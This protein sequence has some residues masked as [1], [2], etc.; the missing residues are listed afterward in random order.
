[1]LRYVLSRFVIFFG[2]WVVLAIHGGGKVSAQTPYDHEAPSGG[3]NEVRTGGPTPSPPGAAAYFVDVKN[4]DTLQTT[5]IIHFGLKGMGIAPAEVVRANS[6]HHHLLIDTELPPLDK[7]IPND[8]QHLHFGAGQTEA[9]V[10]LTPGHH[11][12]QLLLGDKD[13]IPHSPPVM[14]DR[15]NVNVVDS[16]QPTVAAGRTRSPKGARVYFEYPTDGACIPEK[17]V[18]RFGL[19][20]MG[21]APAGFNKRNTGHHHLLIDTELPD[22]NRPIPNDQNHLHFGTGTTE[23]EVTLQPG[24]HELQ[25]LLADSRHIPHDPPLYSKPISVFVGTCAATC[26][27][28]VT[29]LFASNGTVPLAGT[30]AGIA[31]LRDWFGHH[32]DARLLVEGYADSRGS[33]AHNLVLSFAR[34]RSVASIL[35]GKGISTG[36]MTMRAAGAAE[37]AAKIDAQD[38]RVVVSIEGLA[39]CKSTTATT[40]HP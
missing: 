25:L 13:H 1:M 27:D 19:S 30:D 14:S 8:P 22:L 6:G 29:L 10:T 33:D 2:L 4:G 17:A 31:R 37:A 35:A 38:R 36:R 23:A 12:L 39:A 20:G 5:T 24:R 40:E 34:A 16:S 11:T 32:T 18:I 21:I 28:P 9:E 15:I 7:P 3:S 26:F